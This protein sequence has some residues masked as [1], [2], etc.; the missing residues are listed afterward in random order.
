MK[1]NIRLKTVKILIFS[2]ISAVFLRMFYI[3]VLKHK[4]YSDAVAVQTASVYKNRG[5]IY[6][7][8]MIKLRENSS[9]KH[10]LGYVSA[11]GNYG[12]EKAF[13]KELSHC[14]DYGGIS[15]TIDY[16]IQKIAEKAMDN[17]KIKGAVIIADVENG[18]ILAMASRPDFDINK[19]SKN[20]NGSMI[21]KALCAYN[22]GSVFKIITTAAALENNCNEEMTF[23]CE[24]KME[25]DG[26]EFICNKEEGH[27]IINFSKALEQSC[28]CAFYQIGE[29]TGAKSIC[30][31]AKNF[32]FGSPVLNIS[33]LNEESGNIPDG[34]FSLRET[35][36]ISIG[37]GDILVTPLQVADMMVTI[38]N[39]G[40]RKQLKIINGFV[41]SDGFSNKADGINLGRII[42]KSS[43]VKIKNMLINTVENGTGKLA[44]FD[45]EGAGGKTGTAQT[46]WYNGKEMMTHGWFAGF[47]PANQ[48]KYVCVVFAEDGK[49]GSEKAAPVFNRICKSMK[50]R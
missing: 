37:Q 18:D 43:A 46:G 35:A 20:E 15:L 4:D 26:M 34:N 2:I 50:F 16:H 9:L 10:L 31:C 44:K 39:N 41:N 3:S 22:A 38:A 47:F 13:D 5:I 33:G 48:P 30:T 11:N 49:S 21:N 17:A 25:I 45:S 8:N 1:N 6:D 36:N 24:G 28:N 7:R 42:S 32:G 27:G 14:A 12:I 19:G 29:I 23:N 40:I